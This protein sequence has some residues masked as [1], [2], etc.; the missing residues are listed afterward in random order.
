MRREIEALGSTAPIES[1]W[2]H[3]DRLEPNASILA[4]E[5]RL[6]AMPLEVLRR[7]WQRHHPAVR[8]PYQLPRDLLVRSI[9]WQVQEAT[10]GGLSRE[11]L[12][13]LERMAHQLATT[14]TLEIEREV[15]LKTGTRLIREWRGRTYVAEVVEGGI[16]LD[17][18]RYASLSHVARAIT[19]ARWSGPR[20]FGL[21]RNS[22]A[23]VQI[24]GG[25]R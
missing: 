24:A 13:T 18:N 2:P 11:T 21:R 1:K 7:T 19:G 3:S 25:H 10:Y 5:N 14:G 6:L 15:R 23:S 17:G 22:L 9:M 8:M 4:L 12:R 20:F 16:E